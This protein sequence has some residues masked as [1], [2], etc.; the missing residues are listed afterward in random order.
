MDSNVKHKYASMGPQPFDCGNRVTRHL[1]LP[2]SWASM[3]PQPFDCGN[4]TVASPTLGLDMSFNGA[5][6]FRLRKHFLSNRLMRSSWFCFNGAAAFRL[7]KPGQFR[8]HD[9]RWKASM[10]P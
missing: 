4:P 1:Q 7:R 8:G 6:A 3:G 2:R 9:W 5:A 10:G